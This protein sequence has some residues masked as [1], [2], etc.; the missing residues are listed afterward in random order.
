[1]SQYNLNELLK[2]AKGS[3]AQELLNKLSAEDA[4]KIKSVLADKALTER[5]LNSAKAQELIK[6]FMKEGKTNG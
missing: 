5:L 6:K 4:E 3:N 2:T 1:M